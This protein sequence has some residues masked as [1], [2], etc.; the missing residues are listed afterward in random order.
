MHGIPIFLLLLGTLIEG[1]VVDSIT[2]LPLSHVRVEGKMGMV[3]T[4][5]LGRFRMDALPGETLYFYRTGYREKFIPV[6]L[7]FPSRIFLIPVIYK[8]PGVLVVER[9]KK[10]EGREIDEYFVKNLSTFSD[11]WR[12]LEVLP[13]VVSQ[14][15]LSSLLSIR[16]GRIEETGYMIDGIPVA[17]PFHYFGLIGMLPPS[18]IRAI[19]VYSSYVPPGYGGY[20]SGVVDVKTVEK[21]KGLEASLSLLDG[22]LSWGME[23]GRVGMR[24]LVVG[25]FMKRNLEGLYLYPTICDFFIR[26][27]NFYLLYARESFEGEGY[28]VSMKGKVTQGFVYFNILP[29]RI[30]SSFMKDSHTLPDGEG[31][32]FLLTPGCVLKWKPIHAGIEWVRH[33]REGFHPLYH[34]SLDAEYIHGFVAWMGDGDIEGWHMEGGGRMDFYPPGRVL[35]YSL[36]CSRKNFYFSS[37]LSSQYFP[38]ENEIKTA[39][40]KGMGFEW[41]KG[42]LEVF[43]R[44][45]SDGRFAWGVEG[46]FFTGFLVLSLSLW[47]TND[48]K[49]RI[50]FVVNGFLRIPWRCYEFVLRG[51]VIGER[52]FPIPFGSDCIYPEIPVYARVDAGVRLCFSR[53]FAGL[54]IYNLTDKRSTVMYLWEF[55][56]GKLYHVYSLP[57]LLYVRLGV[58]L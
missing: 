31:E 53:F 20:L 24:Y 9:K 55:D 49:M 52:V 29:F 7:P 1:E 18:E 36:R 3:Y 58:K 57:R 43:T 38:E 15:E 54:D 17:F 5:S 50:P 26:G 45:I 21:R 23:E 32:E 42:F 41:E 14:Y 48:E 47:D 2:G 34:T 33:K 46:Y 13:S 35:S 6:N 11:P 40:S 39:V 51:I 30:Y 10:E 8:L 28:G 16:G 56:A 4:D 44:R 22:Y 19:R 25:E 27:R 12:S 37:L